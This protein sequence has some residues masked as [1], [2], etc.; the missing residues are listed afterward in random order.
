MV[1]RAD[2]VK[3]GLALWTLRWAGQELAAYSGRHWQRPEAPPRN[4]PHRPG[5]LRGP[6]ERALRRFG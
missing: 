3:L 4:S 6:S 1:R 2:L 5:W